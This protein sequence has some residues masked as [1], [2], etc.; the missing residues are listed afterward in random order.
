MAGPWEE[1]QAT[2]ESG[3]WEEYT[4]LPKEQ[5]STPL[6]EPITHALESYNRNIGDPFRGLVRAPFSGSYA[7]ASSKD[8]LQSQKAGDYVFQETG[9]PLLATA[10]ATGR[11]VLG[12]VTD[13]LSVVPS[14]TT[15]LM[16]GLRS[17]LQAQR[18]LPN[19]GAAPTIVRGP[20]AAIPG[21]SPLTP[22]VPL[23][24]VPSTFG[25]ESL[26]EMPRN[27]P[28]SPGMMRF[29]SP[30]SPSFGAANYDDI[31]HGP[32]PP[33]RGTLPAVIPNINT[34]LFSE[35]NLRANQRATQQWADE[36]KAANPHMFK[37]SLEDSGMQTPITKEYNARGI[38]SKWF[39]AAISEFART[40]PIG[41][42]AATTW[43]KWREHTERLTNNGLTS[44]ERAADKIYGHRNMF[45]RQQLNPNSHW[46]TQGMWKMSQDE[47]D[48]LVNYLASQGRVKPKG[49]ELMDSAPFSL[50]ALH[51]KKVEEL[52]T[53]FFEST[54]GASAHPG[55]REMRG[56]FDVVKGEWV[57]FGDPN[58]F[59]P[60]IPVNEKAMALQG[61]AF[62]EGFKRWSE[63]NPEGTVSD[64][65]RAIH[66]RSG[67]VRGYAGLEMKRIFDVEAVAKAEG[68]SIAQA[69]R[70][71]GYVS[72]P[73]QALFNYLYGAYGAG[74]RKLAEPIWNK[75]EKQLMAMA[76]DPDEQKWISTM[77]SQLKGNDTETM[78]RMYGGAISAF[79]NLTNA[80]LLQMST[81]MQVNQGVYAISRGGLVN[82]MKA[83]RDMFKGEDISG[84]A[85]ANFADL[86]AT[87]SPSRGSNIRIPFTGYNID[88]NFAKL[89]QNELTVTGF[90]QMDDVLRIFA[91]KVG[92]NYAKSLAV[93]LKAEPGNMSVRKQFEELGLNAEH[94][95]GQGGELTYQDRLQAAK[96][97]AD[98]TQG[99]RDLGGLPLWANENSNTMRLL[100]NLR[101][102]MFINEATFKRDVIDAV[103]NGVGKKE[104][105]ARF[106]RHTVASGVFGEFTKDIV[107]GLTNL[108]APTER[109]P[110]KPLVELMGQEWAR[111]AE[112]YFIGRSSIL[113]AV[114]LSLAQQRELAA[115]ELITPVGIVMAAKM[116]ENPGKI[117]TRMLGGPTAVHQ[118]FPPK[119]KGGI[120]GLDKGPALGGFGEEQ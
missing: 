9:S 74:E 39:G 110:P 118:Y 19:I 81:P 31:L 115:L 29:D 108:E 48:D 40:G 70:K 27:E 77:F 69:L 71:H 47:V 30:Q 35:A 8:F 98:E 46:S 54:K 49:A 57:P 120:S 114:L 94:I 95:L 105:L 6:S 7:P 97:F 61:R 42:E 15:G 112:D 113:M 16:G 60:L 33:S 111:V 64:F 76:H 88:V 75:N 1:Y 99:R 67:D 91:G 72:D 4:Q 3:P 36:Y 73:R 13:P 55:V 65:K 41:K 92:D 83:V 2:K 86:I 37:P 11:E 56:V 24:P 53:A 80:G 106:A 18:T 59:F 22:P 103:G 26:V 5:S 32:Q 45:S 58:M 62:S 66:M 17:S 10:T 119:K 84:P 87:L 23:G 50:E 28:L 104:A 14:L 89:L 63:K 107:H 43:M 117:A 102:F 93:R 82:S 12:A 96:R 25:G 101:N 34:G 38:G 90:T 21:G 44:F 79:N 85:A 109:K 20:E 100:L 68:I 51:A 78:D 116:L 52:A